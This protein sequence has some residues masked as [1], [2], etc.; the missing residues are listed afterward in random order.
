M[1]CA[2]ALLLPRPGPLVGKYFAW[3]DDITA[4]GGPAVAPYAEILPNYFDE[5][6]TAGAVNVHDTWATLATSLGTMA[7]GAQVMDPLPDAATSRKA[8]SSL[9]VP[10]PL[11][12][13]GDFLGKRLKPTE[14]ARKI[15]QWVVHN[16]LEGETT[17]LLNWLSLVVQKTSTA[18]T[19]S[20][21]GRA[22]VSQPLTTPIGDRGFMT[23]IQGKL[24]ERLPGVHN[25]GIS[26]GAPSAQ[27]VTLMQ[28]LIQVQQAA[29]KDANKALA[30]ANRPKT[31][32]EHL[33]VTN[34]SRLLKI[35][36]ETVE[37]NLPKYWSM[38]AEAG[39]KRDRVILAQ[40]VQDCA[41]ALNHED[42]AP[43]VTSDLAKKV[44]TLQIV[45]NNI[46]DLGDG[47]TPFLMMVQDY[48]SPSS[49]RAYF[50]ALQTANDYDM[51][52]SGSSAA[53]LAEIKALRKA[54]NLQMPT[55][56][57]T[58]RLMLQGYT[59]FLA[60]FLGTAHPLVRNL[61]RFVVEFQAKE[62]FYVNQLQLYDASYG[63][64]RLL[65][66]VHLHVR[67]YLDSVW[68]SPTSAH[69]IQAQNFSDALVKMM[70]GD[71]SWLPSLPVQY[72]TSPK[73]PKGKPINDTPDDNESKKKM[74]QIRNSKMNPKFEDFRAGI[75]ATKFNDVIKKVGPPPAVQRNGKT[76][77]MCASYHLRGNCF[78]NCG[79]KEDHAEH[80][81]AKDD[82]LY[83]WCKKAFP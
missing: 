39:G 30:A 64:S 32:T 8:S 19:G 45:G 25:S 42:L 77:P 69:G 23:W 9:L 60:A 37:T 41:A 62:P 70:T 47:V 21:H 72:T 68:K 44:S 75:N 49:E 17:Y 59:I 48:S 38:L 7:G 65:R 31:I 22:K 28:D 51:I 20:Q 29:H 6:P 36:D 52:T 71:M 4:T 27:V 57:M 11:P 33:G 76:V 80:T 50:E 61:G 5:T 82:K 79:R 15:T 74:V 81:T 12:L 46:N 66:Y 54:T 53:D 13:V 26:G 2:N 18:G 1:K 73:A 35:C 14:A 3:Y 56:Y 34:T 83:E 67:F 24:V 55:N 10:L 63:P 43:V 78:D 40:A 58:T 16:S